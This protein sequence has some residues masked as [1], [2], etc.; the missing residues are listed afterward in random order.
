M[1]FNQSKFF[2]VFFSQTDNSC[3]IFSVPANIRAS[4]F[5]YHI[6]N[7]YNYNDWFDLYESYELSGDPQEKNNALIGLTA[8][9]STWLLNLYV[10]VVKFYR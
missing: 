6:Q 3:L 8:S 7:T 5:K 1:M 4:V 10:I 9:R 2:F